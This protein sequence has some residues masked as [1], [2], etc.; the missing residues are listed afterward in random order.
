M[1]AESK[2]REREKRLFEL[3]KRAV[4]EVTS[5]SANQK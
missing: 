1:T 4:R 2:E 5:E 3:I